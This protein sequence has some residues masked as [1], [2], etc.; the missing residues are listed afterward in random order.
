MHKKIAHHKKAGV[1]HPRLC[2]ACQ[3][4]A[5]CREGVEADLFEVAR[6]LK[7]ARL[8]EPKP[9]FY[10]L[11]RDRSFPSGFVFSTVVRHGRCVFHAPDFRCRVYTVRPWFCREFPLESGAKA[12]EYHRL[13]QHGRRH[14]KNKRGA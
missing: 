2:Q 9:W 6:I 8:D 3:V 13:C 14:R 5:C 11:R 7:S 4:G 10:Y 12:P 1:H